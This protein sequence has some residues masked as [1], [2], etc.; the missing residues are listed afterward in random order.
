MKKFH[1]PSILLVLFALPSFTASGQTRSTT[2]ETLP[3]V[4]HRE[5]VEITGTVVAEF[6]GQIVHACYHVCGLT[7]LVKLDGLRPIQYAVIQVKYMDV[8]SMPRNG[9]PVQLV[10][11]AARWSF[12]ATIEL[13]EKKPLQQYMTSIDGQGSDVSKEL[14]I[15]AWR[16]LRGSEHEKIPFGT[17]LPT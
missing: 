12:E 5:I 15:P 4:S 3:G 14:A 17:S 1:L 16:L 9:M 10:K 6:S 7:L 2:P 8:R 11:R 13:G